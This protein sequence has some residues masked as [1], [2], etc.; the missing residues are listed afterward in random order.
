[1]NNDAY[2]RAVLFNILVSYATGNSGGAKSGQEPNRVNTVKKILCGQDTEVQDVF[3]HEKGAH[4]YR[5]GVCFFEED[6]YFFSEDAR[7][8]GEGMSFT[9]LISVFE[10]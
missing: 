5:E 4:Y 8:C 7:F 2:L 6:A 3:F 10:N 1:M 9:L